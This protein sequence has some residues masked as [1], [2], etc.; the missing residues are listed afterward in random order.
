MLLPVA[1]TTI[2][3]LLCLESISKFKSPPPLSFNIQTH[4]FT[5]LSLHES[6]ILDGTSH[7]LRFSSQSN[8]TAS[9]KIKTHP[10]G[11]WK[12]CRSCMTQSGRELKVGVE[13]KKGEEDC[14]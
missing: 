3:F 4:F 9:F 14:L 2:V 12:E 5:H 8:P 11:K 13:V 7:N 6:T 10:A 1:V